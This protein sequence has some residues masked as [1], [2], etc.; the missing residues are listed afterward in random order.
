MSQV[1]C[2]NWRVLLQSVAVE[3]MTGAENVCPALAKLSCQTAGA[4]KETLFALWDRSDDLLTVVKQCESDLQATD[5]RVLYKGFQLPILQWLLSVNK[6]RFAP[7]TTKPVAGETAFDD[8][9]LRLEVDVVCC[10][11]GQAL[12]EN[13]SPPATLA[14][15]STVAAADRP[16]SPSHTHTTAS[17]PRNNGGKGRGKTQPYLRHMLHRMFCYWP[18]SQDGTG[19]IYV[20]PRTQ[21]LKLDLANYRPLQVATLFCSSV[22]SRTCLWQP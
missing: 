17:I 5:I 11:N 21:H 16:D 20:S 22:T 9:E 12:T 10:P 6:R 2:R 19:W 18:R 15:A 14:A 7:S 3:P 1:F 8:L 13:E 4:R